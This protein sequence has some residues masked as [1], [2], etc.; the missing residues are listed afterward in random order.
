M[1]RISQKKQNGSVLITVLIVSGM[2]FL[3]VTALLK[4]G[5]LSSLFGQEKDEKSFAR[6][7]AYLALQEIESDELVSLSGIDKRLPSSKGVLPPFAR[8]EKTTCRG[9]PAIESQTNGLL[10]EYT[11]TDG[12]PTNKYYYDGGQPSGVGVGP[13][14]K[15]LDKNAWVKFYVSN[16][17]D[18][19]AALGNGNSASLRVAAF[20]DLAN[21]KCGNTNPR[22]PRYII[23]TYT[24][25]P[26][27]PPIASPFGYHYRVTVQGYACS[28]QEGSADYDEGRSVT[29]EAVYA[30]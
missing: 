10:D 18:P 3:I 20:K 8:Y 29:L 15:Q 1:L 30:F 25:E 23:E 13:S 19:K 9:D 22:L 11:S 6:Q 4:S 17:P 21:K 16:N 2:V 12:D 28:D 7:A 27:P 26:S 5:I 14:C 24:G